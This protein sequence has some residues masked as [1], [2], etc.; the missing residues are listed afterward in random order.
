MMQKMVANGYTVIST[1]PHHGLISGISAR[2]HHADQ[3]VCR[4]GMAAYWLETSLTADEEKFHSPPMTLR[5]STK[6][7][8]GGS[9]RG[10]STG[11]NE[12]PI[13]AR[14]VVSARVL[15]HSR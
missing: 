1:L 13:S 3:L 10:G 11:K 9:S 14:P 7:Y 5:V 6:W 2:A 15:R 12:N 8:C 4:L